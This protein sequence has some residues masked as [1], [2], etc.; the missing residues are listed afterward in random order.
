MSFSIW[1]NLALSTRTISE[2]RSSMP[3]KVVS[4]LA[5]KS[6][7]R[8]LIAASRFATS[9]LT[10]AK[11][12][13]VFSERAL[14]LVSVSLSTSART[15]A[16][17]SAACSKP[18]SSFFSMRSCSS[19]FSLRNASTVSQI[20]LWSC[21]WMRRAS[22]IFMF[23]SSSASCSRL[24][25]SATS[26]VIRSSISSSCFCHKDLSTFTSSKRFS[27]AKCS[28]NCPCWRSSSFMSI[29]SIWRRSWICSSTSWNCSCTRSSSSLRAFFISSW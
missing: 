8:L 29:S 11:C 21:F 20:S 19:W 23:K 10:A 17:S 16:S 14:T 9:C 4:H 1:P 27:S 6:S 22:V 7:T 12:A 26:L 18:S 24:D 5:V 15:L 2:R 3:L 13:S 25:N 28:S